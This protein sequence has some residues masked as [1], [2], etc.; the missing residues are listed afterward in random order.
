M[1]TISIVD[2]ISELNKQEWDALSFDNVF[3][4]YGWLK[5]AE[6]TYRGNI[7]PKYIVVKH[8]DKLKAAAV[9]Y[10]FGKADLVEDLDELLLGRT[11][12]FASMLGISFMPAFVCWPLLSYGDHLLVGGG[13]DPKQ[14]ALIMRRLLDCIE[15]EASRHNLPVAF[16]NVMDRESGLIK[17]LNRRGYNKSDHIPLSYIDIGWSSFDEYLKYLGNLSSNSKKTVRREINRNR[18]EGTV[19]ERLQDCDE[20]EERL[21]QLLDMNSLKHNGRP[22]NF[23][24]S[25]FRESQ[26]NLGDDVIFY[27]SWKKG[28]LT[29]VSAVFRRNRM[30]HLPMIGVDH[31]KTGDDYTY[32]YLGFYKPMMDAVLDGTMRFYAGRGLYETKA[33]RGFQ[34]ANLYIY[35]RAS[36]KAMNIAIKPWLALL[37]EWNRLKRRRLRRTNEPVRTG[38]V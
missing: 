13:G 37:S 7:S 21:H 35:Y 2:R 34:T 29:G 32:F 10:V 5:T 11:K 18:R 12:G 25:F 33:R 14:N 9:C 27:V 22:F 31:D 30:I 15:E 28:V 8:G 1:C 19:V 38:A 6:A 17:E 26:H 23:S 36:T 20:W 4:S 24:K 3:A 16:V